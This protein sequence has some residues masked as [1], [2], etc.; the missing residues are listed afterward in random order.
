[1]KYLK[2]NFLLNT[3][4]KETKR[5]SKITQTYKDLPRTTIK[6]TLDKKILGS[7]FSNYPQKLEN[8]PKRKCTKISCFLYK[9]QTKQLLNSE[10]NT[11]K[12]LKSQGETLDTWPTP[13]DQKI[14][15][16]ILPRKMYVPVLKASL[17]IHNCLNWL[18]HICM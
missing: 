2:K 5:R 15:E 6:A 11:H 8:D 14:F 13:S 18:A 10:R 16:K 3:N 4:K 17:C 9:N 12:V 1:M 7:N